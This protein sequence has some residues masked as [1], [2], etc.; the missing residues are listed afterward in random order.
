MKNDGFSQSLPTD[1]RFSNRRNLFVGFLPLL[2]PLAL[3][4][5]SVSKRMLFEEKIY[6]A[7]SSREASAAATRLCEQLIGGS[8]KA[9]EAILYEGYSVQR[10]K[11]LNQWDVVCDTPHGDY[12]FRIDADTCR[13]FGI[14][15]L[16]KGNI[17]PAAAAPLSRAEAEA[18]SR[19]Y[20]ALLGVHAE[21]LRS[22][23]LRSRSEGTRW[24]FHYRVAPSDRKNRLMIVSMEDGTGKL[25]SAWSSSP[26]L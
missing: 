16:D 6:A 22:P 5:F 2:V 25:I 9:G 19:R 13:V 1:Y 11:P 20:L 26:Q 12:L 3:C 10:Q 4:L 7:M 17:T 14:N 23:K 21:K 18:Y 24:D 8:V 15:R